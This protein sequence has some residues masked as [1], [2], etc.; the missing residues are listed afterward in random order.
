MDPLCAA[1]VDVQQSNSS[2][3]IVQDHNLGVHSESEWEHLK[4]LLLRRGTVAP[5]EIGV[6][7][8]IWSDA[9]ES[10]RAVG[11]MGEGDSEQSHR[12]H[13]P[14]LTFSTFRQRLLQ[15]YEK[16][17][18]LEIEKALRALED[19]TETLAGTFAAWDVDSLNEIQLNIG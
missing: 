4:R 9:V 11:H 5:H 6:L 18:E 10:A 19:S 16:P 13:P 2:S 14:I 3:S 15:Q 17:G 1:F 7:N 8:T 12:R